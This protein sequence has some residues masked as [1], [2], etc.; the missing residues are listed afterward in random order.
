MFDYALK[1]YTWKDALL[2]GNFAE[3]CQKAQQGDFKSRIVHALVAIVEFLPIISQ[4]SSIFEM[5]IVN[6][7]RINNQH[8]D[9]SNKSITNITFSVK[10][11]NKPIENPPKPKDEIQQ[12]EAQEPVQPSI[13]STNITKDDSLPGNPPSD[14]TDQD[15]NK[16][17]ASMISIAN[18]V[19]GVV[20]VV[21]KEQKAISWE[22]IVK[23]RVSCGSKHDQLVELEKTWKVPKFIGLSHDQM[24]GLFSIS[25]K[26]LWKKLQTTE[27]PFS[28]P[29][30]F[31]SLQNSIEKDILSS[32]NPMEEW[33]LQAFKLL[34]KTTLI[35]RSS[36]NEDGQVVNAGGNETISGVAPT[37][38]DL[39]TAVAKVVS[40]Y[41]SLKS[42]K[43]RASFEKPF[44]ELPLC[45]VLIMEQITEAPDQ[46]I[47]SGVMMTNELGWS[48]PGE[49]GILHITASWGFANGTNNKTICDEW[50][51]G[52]KYCYS[53]I[54]RKLYRQVPSTL[55]VVEQIE[56]KDLRDRPS[57]TNEQLAKLKNVANS[58]EN[59]MNVEFVIKGTDL[60][61]VQARPIQAS[62]LSTDGSY[63]DPA[64]IPSEAKIFKG[65]MII[66]GSSQVVELE[67]S[68][69]VFAKDLAEAEE[70]AKAERPKAVVVYTYESSTTHPALNFASDPSVPC[71][72]LPYN[73]WFECKDSSSSKYLLCTQSGS[74]AEAHPNLVVQNGLFMHPV[75]FPLSTTAEGK[76][77]Q[78]ESDHSFI[79]ELRNLLTTTSELLLDKDR[80]R[81]ILEELDKIFKDIKARSAMC[82]NK[83]NDIY[84]ELNNLSHT[85]FE[86]MLKAAANNQMTQ[87][88][89]HAGMLRQLIGQSGKNVI[90]AHSISGLEAATKIP[91][92]IEKFIQECI[93]SGSHNPLIC[94]LALFALNGFDEPIQ[95][96]WLEF[97]IVNKES[98]LLEKLSQELE[99][100]V[101]MD[102]ATGWLLEN[103]SES[104]PK[105]EALISK[106]EEENK[107]NLGLVDLKSKVAEI[108]D[109]LNQNQIG[110]KQELEKLWK[111]LEDCSNEFIN[112]C[113]S[114]NC[115]HPLIV[116]LIDLWDLSTKAVITQHIFNPSEEKEYFEKR[117]EAFS[118][119]AIVLS[120]AK[121][122]NYP[123][124]EFITH[125]MKASGLPECQFSVQHWLIPISHG[126]IAKIS[127]TDQR[128]TVLHQNLLQASAPKINKKHLPSKLAMAYQ[129]LGRKPSAKMYKEDSQD[130]IFIG[131]D[132]ASVRINIPLY[133][134]S[135]VVTLTQ[136]KG[137]DEIEVTVYMRG[138]DNNRGIH[139][140]FFK[141]FAEIAE[142][143]FIPLGEGHKFQ[144]D[145]K[146]VFTVKDEEKM[147]MLG[148]AIYNLN[149]DT[150]KVMN[151]FESLKEA[152]DTGSDNLKIDDDGCIVLDP[153]TTDKIAICLWN[154]LEQMNK[155]PHGFYSF[156]VI[157]C[158]WNFLKKKN[159]LEK[160]S[161]KVI[162]E[163]KGLQPKSDFTRY[164][165]KKVIEF[166]PIETS[167]EIIWK[168]MTTD[169]ITSTDIPEAIREELYTRLF[170][171]FPENAIKAIHTK[172]CFDLF[173]NLM[174]KI[175]EDTN[176]ILSQEKGELLN[177]LAIKYQNQNKPI[178]DNWRKQLIK[179]DMVYSKK[180]IE[181]LYPKVH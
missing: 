79:F 65:E 104:V 60:Y 101:S 169:V 34:E 151:E 37:E 42:F 28:N 92:F 51:I 47:V 82:S 124:E 1:D 134:H 97:L 89:F 77:L 103:F 39:K 144:T 56:N 6:N 175:L 139:L 146:V 95:M 102:L 85:I 163:A 119:F 46:P 24:Q 164:F 87:V 130:H 21:I 170:N 40:S 178:P 30:L 16:D 52:D 177:K 110:S 115:K 118:H 90:G 142:I 100:L 108:S 109:K 135:T 149:D 23:N 138:F 165:L 145:L 111:K 54:R 123:L 131:N 58:F 20:E 12:I 155:L 62:Q 35:V 116:D 15:N 83:L 126:K 106:I 154:H 140:D 96:K 94:D 105:I 167:K 181:K 64:K 128:L 136:K 71:L 99:V 84:T 9:I 125:N 10:D 72:V 180:Y 74:L 17:T 18:K 59:P 120:K 148:Q 69:I 179:L 26:E 80:Q 113:S 143:P 159:Q 162:D 117:V 78:K 98:N 114:K 55:G 53:T 157:N 137:S 5:I 36:S 41:F 150:N 141:I 19:E 7:F 66:S 70:L 48:A 129:H 75:R 63:L 158:I 13:N 132:Q 173:V 107:I 38:L 161:S 171:E 93:N 81:K 45:S 2:W 88:A 14:K 50:A 127:T 152:L 29:E 4:I 43:N 76:S 61:I 121:L 153:E 49:D 3:H 73:K 31:E 44:K 67:K 22:D 133:C 25:T 172:N 166:L 112:Y 156:G 8:E 57:L 27:S 11:S 91:P 68:E 122:L 33:Q 174:D 160:I 32:S 147:K 176:V 86:N 168:I